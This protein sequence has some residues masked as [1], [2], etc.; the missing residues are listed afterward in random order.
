MARPYLSEISRGTGKTTQK[1]IGKVL[2]SLA[3]RTVL[4]STVDGGV[5]VEDASKTISGEAGG[6]ANSSACWGPACVLATRTS[7]LCQRLPVLVASWCWLGRWR[8]A[9]LCLAI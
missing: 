1:E 3:G 5:D 4:I 7:H 8:D 9:G 2:V 6:S